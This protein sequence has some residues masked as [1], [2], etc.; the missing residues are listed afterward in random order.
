MWA[1][2]CSPVDIVKDESGNYISRSEKEL[3]RCLTNL[4]YVPLEASL[5]RFHNVRVFV[6]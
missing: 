4:D 3:A 6:V 1:G 5:G 2:E